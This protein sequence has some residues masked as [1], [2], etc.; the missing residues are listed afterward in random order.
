VGTF[1]LIPEKL[2]ENSFIHRFIE[3]QSRY[4]VSCFVVTCMIRA[5]DCGVSNNH[6]RGKYR[7]TKA[8]VTVY[9]SPAVLNRTLFTT[10]YL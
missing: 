8:S 5:D 2:S 10:G 3:G 7:E 1:F 6:A 9:M 4:L